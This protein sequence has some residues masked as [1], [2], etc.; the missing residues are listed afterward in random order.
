VRV[1]GGTG[2]GRKFN[3]PRGLQTR[4]A[5][6][7]VRSSIFSRL[8]SRNAIAGASVLD[9]FA[10]SGSLGLEALSRGA[11]RAIFVDNA[12][13]AAAAI[14]RNLTQLGLENHARIV[15]ADFR[16]ALAQLGEAGECFGIIFVDAPFKAD[17][18]AEVLALIAILGLLAPDGF[19][20]TRQF[21]RAEI[22]METALECENIAKIGDHRI[23]LYRRPRCEAASEDARASQSA[24]SRLVDAGM[25]G[26]E[27]HGE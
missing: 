5:T 15:A 14:K 1:I 7:R 13:T 24:G 10:G 8:A 18:T 23:A 21:Y 27:P 2:R 20:V 17:A 12:R 4:P 16:R 22:P 6:A 9:I 11:K 26:K 25:S 19:V 3:A